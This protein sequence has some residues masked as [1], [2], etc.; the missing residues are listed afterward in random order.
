M[1]SSSACRIVARARLPRG[2]PT[3]TFFALLTTNNILIY[4][5][6]HVVD[7][8]QTPTSL[9]LQSSA[10]P[11]LSPPFYIGVYIF[12]KDDRYDASYDAIN[13]EPL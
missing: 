7:R 11:G 13:V 6:C 3:V 5:V 8:E 9:S 10:G 4:C 2:D 1:S 12:F